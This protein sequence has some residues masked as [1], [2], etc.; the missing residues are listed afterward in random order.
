MRGLKIW[1]LIVYTRNGKGRLEDKE[2]LGEN[3]HVLEFS[4]KRD[5]VDTWSTICNR[6]SIMSKLKSRFCSCNIINCR[7][8]EIR[9]K[10][11]K[12]ILI[13]A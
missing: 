4:I 10:L 1:A 7:C 9:K 3:H 12:C 11:A 13:H 8:I 2:G 5:V 6:F